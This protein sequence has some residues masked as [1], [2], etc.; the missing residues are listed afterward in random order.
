MHYFRVVWC[1]TIAVLAMLFTACGNDLSRSKAK[2]EIEDSITFKEPPAIYIEI[3]TL[4]EQCIPLSP[5]RDKGNLLLRELG[6]LRIEKTGPSLWNVS[7]TEKGKELFARLQQTPYGGSKEKGC[8]YQQITLPLATR[9]IIEVTG[10]QRDG[11]KSIAEFSWKWAP[12][13][14]GRA[15]FEDT[16]EYK[17]L[18]PQE[19][20]WLKDKVEGGAFVNAGIAVGGVDRSII[21]TDFPVKAHVKLSTATFHLYDDGWRLD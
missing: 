7:L 14:F 9:E 10:I 12:T 4:G 16:A 5:E 3:G 6:I 18:T 1:F 20:E 13:E 11:N 19:K 21:L 15:L 8:D 17:A 2:K